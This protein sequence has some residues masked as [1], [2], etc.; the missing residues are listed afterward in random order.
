M[1]LKPYYMTWRRSDHSK[2][3]STYFIRPVALL[4][5]SPQEIAGGFSSFLF[6]EVTWKQIRHFPRLA[7]IKWT[8]TIGI[9]HVNI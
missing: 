2:T 9:P 8:I 7:Q 4:I 3:Q 5:L 1:E 6:I